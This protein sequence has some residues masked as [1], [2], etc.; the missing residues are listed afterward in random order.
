MIRE[1]EDEE[2]EEEEEE[3]ERRHTAED[4]EFVVRRTAE[5]EM[6]ATASIQIYCRQH[7]HII[8]ANGLGRI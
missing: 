5:L 8:N 6:D 7:H 4:H 3:E 2:E 1:K